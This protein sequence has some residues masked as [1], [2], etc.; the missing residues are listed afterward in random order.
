VGGVGVV[1]QLGDLAQLG[2]HGAAGGLGGVGGED[3]SYAEVGGGLAQVLGIGVLEH[4][5]GAGQD[6][7]LGRAPGAQLA[8]AVDLLGDIGEV[9]VGGEG[10]DQLGGGGQVGLAQEPGGGLAVGPG[11][12]PYALDQV[13]QLVAFL[14][15][16][17]LAEEV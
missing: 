14:A 10:P 4:V 17:G 6:A 2:Q 3:G 9:E 16:E 15:D 7:A 5:G 8:A 13:Q 12:G 1:Q 11:Q